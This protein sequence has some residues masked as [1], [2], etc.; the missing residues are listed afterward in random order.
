MKRGGNPVGDKADKDVKASKAKGSKR[1]VKMDTA[2]ENAGMVISDKAIGTKDTYLDKYKQDGNEEQKDSVTDKERDAGGQTGNAESHMV[3]VREEHEGH[4]GLK[5]VAE[6]HNVTTVNESMEKEGD[7]GTQQRA[8]ETAVWEAALRGFKESLKTAET[9]KE[10]EK[11]KTEIGLAQMMLKKSL[12]QSMGHIVELDMDSDNEAVKMEVIGNDDITDISKEAQEEEEKTQE[13]TVKVGPSSA[14]GGTGKLKGYVDSMTTSEKDRVQEDA[15]RWA[16]MSDDDTIVLGN[17]SDN[18]NEDGWNEVKGKNTKKLK[19]TKKNTKKMIITNNHEQGMS[20]I[21][22][23]GS[24]AEQDSQ[25]DTNLASIAGSQGTQKQPSLMSYLEMVKGKERKGNKNSIWVTTSF[26]PRSIGYGDYIRV[27]KNV[28]EYAR[29][30]DSKVML[31]PWDDKSNMGPINYDDFAN[32]KNTADRIKYYFNKPAYINL[33]Q[34]TPVYGIGICFSTDMEKY[35][36]Y[37]RWNLQK[38]VYKQNKRLAY[39]INLSATQ[40]TSTAFIIGIAVGST[41]DQDFGGI[42]VSF[43]NVN[44]VGVTQEF[45][46]IANQKVK[47]ANTDKLSRDHLRMKYR[48]APNAIAVFVPN[49]ESVNAA[50]K[51]MQKKYGKAI[52]GNDPVWPD[53]S[54]MRFLPIKG[55][56]IKNEKMLHNVKKRMTYHISL[57]VNEQVIETNM[58]NIYN[59]IDKFDGR[60][61]VDIVLVQQTL[62]GY[63]V[64]THFNRGW[65]ND[66]SRQR[67]LLSIKFQQREEAQRILTNLRHT[68]Y[69]EY[70]TDINQ[71]CIPENDQATWRNIVTARQQTTDDDND[72]FDDDED[73]EEMVRQGIVDSSFLQM[74]KK[75]GSA[76]Q[77][78]K[79][80][81]VSWGT[82]KTAYTVIVANQDTDDMV[83]SSLTSDKNILIEEE[84]ERRMD[85]VRVCL[86]LRG[87]PEEEIMAV[88]DKKMPYSLAFSGINLP[89]WD[90]KT[91]VFIIMALWNKQNNTNND[92][93]E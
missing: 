41:E 1:D 53:G 20:I 92:H 79:D 35:E 42:E 34:G 73:I 57:K 51:I 45:W 89:T 62:N 23:N 83:N 88:M 93:D 64:F 3:L 9:N 2:G 14:K 37:N 24:Y 11:M 86:S 85:I 17:Q 8:D 78:D 19:N 36:F 74:F 31:L 77:D 44:Q 25:R 13:A 10:R 43:Q 30:F 63:R 80:S 69:E 60:T 40:K 68:L 16:D 75:N 32:V 70:G 56:V 21:G 55:P 48:W 7:K 58:A 66:P 4:E 26:A 67:W 39:S 84:K 15:P 61:F 59:S 87:V 71:F 22:N 54:Q 50:R 38:S 28:L 90:P 82:G 52:N 91:E 65:T 76:D 49:K 5:E 6:K 12:L 47:E 46:K 29:E 18:T 72:W 27:T 33:Q 81:V